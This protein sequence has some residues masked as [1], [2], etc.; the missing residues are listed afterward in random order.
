MGRGHD[1]D[2]D[3]RSARGWPANPDRAN[4]GAAQTGPRDGDWDTAAASH[5]SSVHTGTAQT[6]DLIA[7]GHRPHPAA[8][9]P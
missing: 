5:S 3:D 7:M 9:R 6:F 2:P 8:Y 4:P 1:F